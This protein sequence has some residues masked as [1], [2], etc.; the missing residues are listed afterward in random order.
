MEEDLVGGVFL[1]ILVGPVGLVLPK[2]GVSKQ[3]FFGTCPE[4][5]PFSRWSWDKV[6][7]GIS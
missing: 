2:G 6:M 4:R 5:Y 7:G 3:R 1:N